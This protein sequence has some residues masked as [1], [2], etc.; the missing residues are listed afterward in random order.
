[1]IKGVS[2]SSKELEAGLDRLD[3]S[4]STYVFFCLNVCVRV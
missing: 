3:I 2:F 1:M 4:I